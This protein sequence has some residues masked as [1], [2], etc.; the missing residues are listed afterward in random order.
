VWAVT[1]AGKNIPLDPDPVVDGN[2]ERVTSAQDGRIVFH[3]TQYKPRRDCEDVKRYRS[4]FV[5]CPQASQHR[6]P[7]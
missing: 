4:H 3:V 2:L 1:A 7:R 5:S 6:R